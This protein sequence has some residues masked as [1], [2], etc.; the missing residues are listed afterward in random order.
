MILVT[1]ASGQVGCAVIRA[2]K[3]KGLDVRAFI[4]STASEKKVREAGAFEVFVGDMNCE[5]DLAHAF[6]GVEAVYFICPAADPCEDTIGQKMIQAAKARGDIYFVYHSVLHSVLQ[7]MPHHK[8]KLHVE[9]MLV[10]SGL[11]YAITQ[12]AVFMQML[13]PAVKSV[14]SGGPLI[15]KFYLTNKTRMN[16]LHLDDLG[17]AVGE[18]FSSRKYENG[19]F[20]L[21]GK[22]NLSLE[23]LEAAFSQAIGKA[24]TSAYIPDEVFLSQVGTAS[25]TYKAQTLLAM[26]RHYN[27]HSFC[28]NSQVLTQILGRE[29]HTLGEFI[30]E[31]MK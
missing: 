4:H 18:I 23:D 26:F 16:L 8:K 15:Q 30:I 28:G 17:E 3:R 9:Q 20:E 24:V 19:T 31:N 13:L 11:K 1:G 10:D 6:L 27:S 2:L 14:C 21:C 12:P 7:D 29:P 5:S 25:A 22:E